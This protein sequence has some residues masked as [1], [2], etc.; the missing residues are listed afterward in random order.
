MSYTFSIGVDFNVRVDI[1][2]LLKFP[3]IY[4]CTDSYGNMGLSTA[5]SLDSRKAMLGEFIERQYFSSFHT[6]KTSGLLKEKASPNLYHSLICLL[7]QTSGKDAAYLDNYEFDLSSCVNLFEGRKEHIPSVLLSLG[8]HKDEQ[9]VPQRDSCGSSSHVCPDQALNVALLE[10]VERQC[11]LA[12]WL[13]KLCRFLIKIESTQDLESLDA[14]IRFI[15]DLSMV[16]NVYLADI[17]LGLS[18]Y[19]VLAAFSAFSSDAHVQFSVGCAAAL[20]PMDAVVKALVEMYQSYVLMMGMHSKADKTLY[21][22]ERHNHMKLATNFGDRNDTKTIEDFGFFTRHGTVVKKLQDY[23]VLPPLETE[24]ILT[25]LRTISEN[26]LY[27]TNSFAYGD[28]IHIVSKVFNPDFYVIM[29]NGGKIN[30]AN[31]Y[32]TFLG[33]DTNVTPNKFKPLPFA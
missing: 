21:A 16:G 12:S 28:H 33:V 24:D 17:S 15:R 30:F 1:P 18:G 4:V 9:L 10:F 32:S 23:I 19:V 6:G 14:N 26:L 5:Y 25:G 3:Y 11:L 22:R 27:Y 2:P 29:D 20:K 8:K 7:K 31:K 13:S